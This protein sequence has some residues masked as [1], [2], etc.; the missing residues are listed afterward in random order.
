MLDRPAMP[1]YGYYRRTGSANGHFPLQF[2]LVIVTYTTPAAHTVLEIH[3]S[4]CLRCCISVDLTFSLSAGCVVPTVF[5]GF[6][7]VGSHKCLQCI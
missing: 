3:S 7:H 5:Y 6:S 1:S 4:G 2:I